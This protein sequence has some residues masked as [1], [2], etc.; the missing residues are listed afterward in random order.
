MLAWV[1]SVF[2]D[3]GPATPGCAVAASR[4]GRP[5]F[6]RAYGMAEAGRRA[7]PATVYDIGS[8]AKQFTAMSVVL[9][10]QDGK[11]SL[12]IE[13]NV[14]PAAISAEVTSPSPNPTENVEYG[15]WM[16]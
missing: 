5:L 15:P 13:V 2:A 14:L 1:D 16:V 9:L 10:A 11:L 4:E 8:V 12:G 6:A 7:T 3:F